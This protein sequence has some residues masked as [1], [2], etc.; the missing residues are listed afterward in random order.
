MMRLA[1]VSS[2]DIKSW[3]VSLTVTAKRINNLLIPLRTIFE[4]A[5][6]EELI[7]RNPVARIKNLTVSL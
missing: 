7:D 1:D 3:I 5:F 6:S 2:S 4:D